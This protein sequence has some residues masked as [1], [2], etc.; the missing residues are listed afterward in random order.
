MLLFAEVLQEMPSFQPQ[1][2]HTWLDSPSME[3]SYLNGFWAKPS[4]PLNYAE[5]ILKEK[6]KKAAVLG[7][8]FVML[9]VRGCAVEGE[10]GNS[11]FP[12]LT[13]LLPAL[14]RTCISQDQ[15]RSPKRKVPRTSPVLPLV[16]FWLWVGK[17]SESVTRYLLRFSLSPEC[18]KHLQPGQLF[19][20]IL[21]TRTFI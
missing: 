2:E 19:L 6:K 20:R 10:M 8:H 9:Q 13:P 4:L 5:A 17:I 15:K 14:L 12:V 18:E 1:Q 3:Q 7:P 21:K 16:C 11:S